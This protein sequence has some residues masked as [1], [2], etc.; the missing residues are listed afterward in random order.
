MKHCKVQ[1]LAV[2]TVGFAL[3]LLAGC[4]TFT[5][6]AAKEHIAELPTR[7]SLVSF[8]IAQL[9]YGNGARFQRC[10]ERAC[11]KTTEKTFASG[12]QKSDAVPVGI[13]ADLPAMSLP[14]FQSP[15]T[16]FANVEREPLIQSASTIAVVNFASGVATLTATA[17]KTLD[18]VA[19]QAEGAGSLEIRGRTDESGS[20]KFNEML[21]RFRA[22]AARDYL[23]KQLSRYVRMHVSFKGTCCYVDGND[24]EEG[25]AANRRVEIEFKR[26]PA[27][28]AS[29]FS[30]D[31]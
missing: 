17:R 14:S 26:A 15:A 28:E 10:I 27:A 6:S 11:P 20:A 3:S 25:R 2:A 24:T 12:T 22:V 31:P 5:T 18:A 13:P 21:A 4:V 7:P 9:Q 16:A 8:A 23:Q 29:E 19:R 30:N 1:R